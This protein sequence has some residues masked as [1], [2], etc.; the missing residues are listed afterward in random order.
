MLISVNFTECVDAFSDQ[1]TQA[2]YQK[3]IFA[4]YDDACL[5]YLSHN[6]IR[7][8]FFSFVSK[9]KN[10]SSRTLAEYHSN[11]SRN[12]YSVKGWCMPSIGKNTLSQHNTQQT[13]IKTPGKPEGHV[14]IAPTFD[15]GGVTWVTLSRVSPNGQS[16]ICNFSHH[17]YHTKIISRSFIGQVSV[18]DTSQIFILFGLLFSMHIRSFSAQCLLSVPSIHLENI[19]CRFILRKIDWHPQGV[20]NST[21]IYNHETRYI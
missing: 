14:V 1:F 15:E 4:V 18:W 5:V 16:A 10:S 20:F 7:Q 21:I 6:R 11:L 17:F 9:K 8:S 2:H 3:L 19:G 13:T 12:A